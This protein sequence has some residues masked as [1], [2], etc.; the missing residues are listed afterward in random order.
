MSAAQLPGHR[1]WAAMDADNLFVLALAYSE[2]LIA[3]KLGVVVPFPSCPVALVPQHFSPD[4]V[5]AQ[6][7]LPP[8]DTAD[9]P[10]TPGSVTG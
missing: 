3:E 2:T 4:V 10:V 7:T 9:A 8:L 1:R 5:T 6:P